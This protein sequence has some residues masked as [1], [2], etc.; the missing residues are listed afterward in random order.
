MNVAGKTAL[1]SAARDIG[2]WLDLT[3]AQ[4][5]NSDINVS[6]EALAQFE[7]VFKRH[8]EDSEVIKK[9]DQ[10]YRV[11][12]Q[13]VPRLSDYCKGAVYSIMSDFTQLHR[14]GFNLGLETLFQSILLVIADLW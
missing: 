12:R 1:T 10:V 2:A 7:E 13:I 6:M 11:S 14:S 4:I 5:N 3:I 8:N 9:I